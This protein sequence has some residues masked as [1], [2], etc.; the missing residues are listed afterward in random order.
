MFITVILG[1]ETRL[2]NT[3]PTNLEILGNCGLNTLIALNSRFNSG[4]EIPV[5]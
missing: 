3:L 5:E 2:R 1:N 4:I